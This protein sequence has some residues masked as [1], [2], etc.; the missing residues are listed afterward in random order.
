MPS[1]REKREA[2]ITLH[3]PPILKK[4][5][6]EV[7]AAEDRPISTWLMRLAEKDPSVQIVMKQISARQGTQ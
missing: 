1:R 7:A 4:A 5:L 3:A 6:R 2:P